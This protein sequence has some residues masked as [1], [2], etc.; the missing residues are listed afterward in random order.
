MITDVDVICHTKTSDDD[1]YNMT[2]IALM[3][4]RDSEKD[5]N[6]KVHLYETDPNSTYSYEGLCYNYFRYNE[7]YNCATVI[8]L[9]NSVI[10][11]DWV[12]IINNDLRFERGWFSKIVDVH[13]QRPDIESFTPKDPLLYA[14]FYDFHFVGTDED[15]H[16]SH[17]VTEFMGGWCYVMKKRVWDA[18]YPWDDQFAFYYADNDYAE[19]IKRLGIKHALVRDSIVFHFGSKTVGKI[20]E[21]ARI[22]ELKFLRK[23]DISDKLQQD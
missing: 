17:K 23:W 1:V 6:F 7:P 5:Y 14:Q 9:A 15:Y 13:K 19:K 2:K 8:N 10:T 16:E 21:K 3:M 11:H 22:D 18:V 20:S 12:L 4:L